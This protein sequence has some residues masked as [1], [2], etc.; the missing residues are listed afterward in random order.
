MSTVRSRPFVLALYCFALLGASLALNAWLAHQVSYPP[1][2]LRVRI[3][4]DSLERVRQGITPDKLKDRV[5]KVSAVFERE[6]GIRLSVV[7]FTDV[8]I[9]RDLPDPESLRRYLQVRTPREESDIL[10]AFWPASAAE[11]LAGSAD[12]FTPVAVVRLE[13]GSPGKDL[14]L[15]AHQIG[16]LYGLSDSSDPRSLMHS[17]P[18]ELS[19]D[20]ASRE[21][22]MQHRLFDFREGLGGISGRMRRRI[23]SS[24]ES[25][26]LA[27]GENNVSHAHRTLGNLLVRDRQFP[28]AITQFRIAVAADFKNPANHIDLAQALALSQQFPEAIG[29]AKAA[30]G[31]DPNSGDAHY[32]LGYV[33]ARSGNP[34]AAV[35]EFRKAVVL[36]PNTARYHAGLA[37]AYAGVIGEFDAST[38]EFQE[39]ERLNA[40]DPL[41]KADFLYVARLRDRL[42]K[43]LDHAATASAAN[44][45]NPDA[46]VRWAM[47]LLRLG[48]VDESMDEVRKAIA[49]GPETWQMHYALAVAW[50]SKGKF[51]DAQTAFK[52]AQELGS[53][54][55]PGFEESLQSALS[56]SR[57]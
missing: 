19:L 29:E 34:D 44:P 51:T 21:T 43:E 33:L 56:K 38:R 9:G 25:E 30:I 40:S 3:I 4:T 5:N 53:G 8:R 26:P 47:L 35:P 46:R 57:S 52:R 28:E 11:T 36:S 14:S 18:T 42:E 48:K 23:I 22:L 27:K 55:R 1:V 17:P 12:P 10:V 39:A 13:A 6:A 45:D 15:L 20:T 31:L 49:Q 24:F 50:Y 37:V 41:V 32:E 7:G 2:T 16:R 54:S